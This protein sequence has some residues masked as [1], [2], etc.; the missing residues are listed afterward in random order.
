[1]ILAVLGLSVLA[2]CGFEWITRRH[3]PTRQRLLAVA[4]GALL[5]LECSG[6]PLQLAAFR[7]DPP[8]VDRW[9]AEQ[10]TP[11]AIAEIPVGVRARFQTTYMLHSM[12]HWQKTIQGYSGVQAPLHDRLFEELKY[13][14]DVRSLRSLAEIG[15]THVVVHEDMFD[16]RQWADVE[17]R[18]AGFS[19]WL[20]LAHQEGKGRIY[21]LQR[22]EGDRPAR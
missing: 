13:F 14:P 6:I 16:P 7:T 18:L 17:P 9:L 8:G 19:Q 15:V 20:T 10:A 1:M 4:V 3:A 5:I 21:A 12:A 22:P 2:G 11:I